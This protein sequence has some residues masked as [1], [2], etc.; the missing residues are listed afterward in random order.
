MGPW[1]GG[2]SLEV[3]GGLSA[4]RNEGDISKGVLFGTAT[5]AIVGGLSGGT[6]DK[7]GLLNPA[8]GVIFPSLG[9]LDAF[10]AGTAI[11][12]TILG[13]GKGATEAYAGGRGNFR[14]IIGGASKAGIEGAITSPFTTAFITSLGLPFGGG[15]PKTPYSN[16]SSP[17]WNAPDGNGL[18]ELAPLAI[19]LPGGLTDS[20]GEAG[21]KVGFWEITR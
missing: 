3:A 17:S 4:A 11:S 18:G 15:M 5:G 14:S 19:T 9:T 21:I 12:G 16:Y 2:L 8:G 13:A 7:F 20:V 10:A 1:L 6:L